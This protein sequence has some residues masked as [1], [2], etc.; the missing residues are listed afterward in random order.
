MIITFP[1][2]SKKEFE[3]GTKPYEIASSIS[4][5]LA[6][7]SIYALVNDE[8][9]DLSRPIL[10]DAKIQFKKKEE[11]FAV[12]NHSCSH[13]L[14]SAVKALYPNAM[15]GVGPS[16]EEGFYYD[17]Q[18][19]DGIKFTEA[20]L[21]LIEKEMVKIVNKDLKFER[22]ET[23]KKE[24][25]ELFKNDKYKTEIINDLDENNLITLYRHGDY[26]DLCRGPHV[27]ST[28]FLKNFKLTH[29]SGA[30]WRGDSK[31]EQLQRI[32]GVCF[33]DEKELNFYLKVLPKI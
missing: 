25:L 16:I 23:T 2:G 12:L 19:G 17:I 13:L 21:P 14:A 1:D 27:P 24:A 4:P 5:S 7:Q 11:S 32:Y 3:K 15:F 9:Y 31:N 18:P 6:K 28:K 33:F 20:D 30:Y 29:V 8:E 22:I 10:N 26:V